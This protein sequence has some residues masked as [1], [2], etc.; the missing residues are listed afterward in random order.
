MLIKA[1]LFYERNQ[2]YIIGLAMGDT[3]EKIFKPSLTAC[4]FMA[5]S[6]YCKWK[7]SI[8][9]FLCHTSC[10][11]PLLLKHLCEADV[12]KLHSIGLDV[13]AVTSDMGSK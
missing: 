7:Q 6:I 11:A 13:C 9:Y 10:P 4:V 1:N 2:N 8:A 12:Q 5:R 3:A